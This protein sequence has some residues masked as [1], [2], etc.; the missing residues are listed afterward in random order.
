MLSRYSR[1][2]RLHLTILLFIFMVI[3]QAQSQTVRVATYN[4]KFL[5]TNVSS[6]GDRG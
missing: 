5:D 1:C 2:T 6:Q 3:T 4:I